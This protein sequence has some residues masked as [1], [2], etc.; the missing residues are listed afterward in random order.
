[1]NVRSTFERKAMPLILVLVSLI[2]LLACLC[3]AGPA[4]QDHVPGIVLMVKQQAEGSAVLQPILPVQLAVEMV[5]RG[6]DGAAAANGDAITCKAFRRVSKVVDLPDKMAG[7]VHELA[8]D[9]G[10]RI[11][12]V[13]GVLFSNDSGLRKET[14]P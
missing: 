10:G 14:R 7:V 1:M 3:L 11:Y 5:T 12:V 9:C 2:L 4:P 8:L 13:K 6:P